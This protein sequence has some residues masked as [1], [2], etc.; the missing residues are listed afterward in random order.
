MHMES[1]CSSGIADI[2]H[3]QE[4]FVLQVSFSVDVMVD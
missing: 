4:V 2:L 3:F 1:L